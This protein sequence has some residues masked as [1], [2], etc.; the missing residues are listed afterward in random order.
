[1]PLS[2]F[3]ATAYHLPAA[4]RLRGLPPLSDVVRIPLGNETWR[5]ETYAHLR[6]LLRPVKTKLVV[7]P[8]WHED[9]P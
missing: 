5:F 8:E 7:R 9:K 3:P 2:C 4:F 6:R 1:L